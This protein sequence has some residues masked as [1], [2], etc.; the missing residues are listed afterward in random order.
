[1]CYRGRCYRHMEAG[2]GMDEGQFSSARDAQVGY[3]SNQQ[4]GLMKVVT[5]LTKAKVVQF[6]AIW[7]YM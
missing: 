2:Q 5:S 6:V 7:N 4:T 1:M 3:I